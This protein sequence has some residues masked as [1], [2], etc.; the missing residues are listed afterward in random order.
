MNRESMRN[1]VKNALVLLGI[2]GLLATG[3]AAAQVPVDEDGNPISAIGN[4]SDSA[5]PIDEELPILTA[6][7]LDT[8]VGPIALY[9]DNLLAIVL[10]ASTYPLEI[11]QAARFL[12]RLESDASLKPDDE[13]D[14][15][16]VA[17]L[18]YPEVVQMMSDD[19]DW[20]WKL[21][22][23]VVAQQNDLIAAIESFRD[24]AYAAGNLKTDDRQTVTY[25]DDVIEIAPINEEIIYV[26]YYEPERVVVYSPRPVY[27]YYPHA[28]PVYYYPYPRNHYFSSGYFWGVTTVFSIGWASDYLHV[29]HHSYYSHPYYGRSY[30]GNYWRRPSLHVH[31]SYYVN[32]RSR[33]SHNHYSHGDYW[34][35]RRRGGARPIRHVARSNY[36]SSGHHSNRTSRNDGDGRKDRL[37]LNNRQSLSSGSSNSRTQPTGANHP[38]NSDTRN[39]SADQVVSADRSRNRTGNRSTSGAATRP[40]FEFRQRDNNT[41]TGSV[42][43]GLEGGQRNSSGPASNQP[44]NRSR[45]ASGD[46]DAISFRSRENSAVNRPVSRP[47]GST[48]SPARVSQNSGQNRET[49]SASGGTR[50]VATN[51][52]RRSGPAAN[53]QSTNRPPQA[54]ANSSRRQDAK[55]RANS[56]RRQDAVTSQPR[57]AAVSRPSSSQRPSPPAQAQHTPSSRPSS[58]RPSSRSE[59]PARSSKGSRESSRGKR[60]RDK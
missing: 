27:Y 5:T 21:G 10:P 45:D 49:S 31:N 14:D 3:N 20:T 46:A 4:I 9:P 47:N 38:S 18:N 8:L 19:I 52:T 41:N 1:Y 55:A 29:H 50:S 12:E 23:A 17:L 51:S 54:R 33:V 48:I 56:S 35:P 30:Y 44:A 60:N 53:S 25:E 32:H 40:S 2:M 7:E 36:Y 13:W 26:P 22:E 11:V 28:Y 34:R 16:V 37:A 39:H 57:P 58:S 15:S 43:T 59:E 42:A 24:R 6:S